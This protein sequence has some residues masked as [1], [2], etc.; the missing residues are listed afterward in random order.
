MRIARLPASR[1][2]WIFDLDNTLHDARPYFFPE[3]H[4]QMNQWLRVNLNL[5]EAGANALRSLF[6]QKYGTTM[7]GLVR[8][9][10][11]NPKRFI[12]ETHNF[13]HY[14]ARVTYDNALHHALARLP[15][16]KLIFSNAPRHYVDGVLGAIG[17]RR[18][19]S[20]I[21]TI[22]DTR[23]RPKPALHGFHVLMR[24]HKLDPHRCAFIDDALENLHAA[25]RLGLETV[26]VSRGLGKPRFVDARIASVLELPGLAFRNVA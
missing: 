24:A 4:V 7:A 15:G 14:E 13:R 25:K 9:Y 23:Y 5:D 10:G 19:F 3:M 18:F 16:K 6:W 21:Y 11:M 26:W 20:A 12:Q 8:H 1:R 17:V 2:V 22:E